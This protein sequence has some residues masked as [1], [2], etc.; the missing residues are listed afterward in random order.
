MCVY[1]IYTYIY[2]H[3]CTLTQNIL[4]FLYINLI[5]NYPPEQDIQNYQKLPLYSSSNHAPPTSPKRTAIR[6][7]IT[8]I[9]LPIGGI[10]I[11]VIIQYFYV[12]VCFLPLI[13]MSVR[14]SMLLLV[15]IDFLC[16]CHEILHLEY[17]YSKIILILLFMDIQVVSS[18]SLYQIMVLLIF[19]HLSVHIYIQ[20]FNIQQCICCVMRYQ[21]VLLQEIN[22][23]T[24]IQKHCTYSYSH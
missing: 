19:K 14:L 8:Q 23:Q 20:I 10:C 21:H 4:L 7:S 1:Y 5:Y 22:C 3:K 24:A 11:N 2:I 6:T 13:A 12:Y 16:F 18:I 9:V 15:E 17:Q